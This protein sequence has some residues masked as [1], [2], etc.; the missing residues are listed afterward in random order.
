MSYQCFVP[1]CPANHA[2]KYQVC[3]AKSSNQQL[4]EALT[5]ISLWL[6]SALNCKQWVWD[7]DQRLAAMGCL[8]T[9]DE[10]LKSPVETP[11]ALGPREPNNDMVICPNCTSQF[12]AIPVNV[13]SRLQP[14]IGDVRRA[15]FNGEPIHDMW[16]RD[17]TAAMELKGFI[18][19]TSQQAERE[20]RGQKTSPRRSEHSDSC[21]SVR[22]DGTRA[23]DCEG[24]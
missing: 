18:E 24:P 15:L 10:L 4:R 1:G 20:R 8:A 14:F 5:D 22:T 3:E 6:R 12:V 17:I 23:C 2:S 21:A 13:Q 16:V 9:A 7:S 11:I 19:S